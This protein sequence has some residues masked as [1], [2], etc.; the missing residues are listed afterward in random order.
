MQPH[1]YARSILSSAAVPVVFPFAEFQGKYLMDCLS[2]GWNV[3]MISGID[4]CVQKVGDPSKIV[5]DMIVMY[6]ERIEVLPNNNYT[7]L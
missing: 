1:E 3:N 2:S 6:P 7:T 4:K 5:V